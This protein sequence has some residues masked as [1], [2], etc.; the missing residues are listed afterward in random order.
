MSGISSGAVAFQLAYQ[1]SPIVMTGGIA[2]AL[3]GS[4]LPLLSLSNALSFAGGLLTPG[5]VAPSTSEYFAYFQPLPGGTLID[6]QIGMYPFANQT[7]AA[8]AVIQQPLVISMQMVCPAGGGGGYATKA[9]LMQSLQSSFDQH[10]KSGG[11]Y[12]ILTPFFPYVDCVMTAMTDISRGDTKQVQNTY[13]LDF[14]KPL[15][16]LAAAQGAQNALMSQI[17][18]GVPTGL[19][20][21]LGTAAGPA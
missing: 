18:G 5:S 14:L 10:N 9:A 11:L 2:S 7:V 12:T 8:N 19:S 20:S 13:K 4:M 21:S 6:Q 17:S 3:P 15:V 1:I 16:S